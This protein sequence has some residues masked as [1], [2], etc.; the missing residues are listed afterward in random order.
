[1]ARARTGFTRIEAG[2]L[3]LNLVRFDIAEAIREA[4]DCYS[5][6]LIDKKQ[7]LGIH[8]FDGPHCVEGDKARLVQVL[9]NLISNA[10]K[11]S[12]I[13][14]H[15]VISA[16]PQES[17]L[18]I[19]VKDNGTGISQDDQ[20]RIFEAFYRA[21]NQFTRSESGTGLGLSIVKSLV[22]AHGGKTWIAS[23]SD[24]GTEVGF[25]LPVGSTVDDAGKAGCI[26][27][28]VDE[29]APELSVQ[30]VFR[31]GGVCNQDTRS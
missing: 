6:A 12:P 28:V 5:P 23:P 4:V 22:E 13:G 7:S 26:D 2:T 14:S 30:F 15:I 31:A 11:Y 24:G 3:E 9:T 21:D 20:K 19:F 18:R 1:M 29:V 16:E 27:T 25:S 8:G 10:S 17:S